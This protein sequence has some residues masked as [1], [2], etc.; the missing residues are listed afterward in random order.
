MY[1]NIYIYPNTAFEFG[2]RYECFKLLEYHNR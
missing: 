1:M 2:R